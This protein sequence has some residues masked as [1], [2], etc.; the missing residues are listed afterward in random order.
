M[1]GRLLRPLITSLIRDD[2][3]ITDG[4]IYV[5]NNVTVAYLPDPSA[6]SQYWQ[7]SKPL[8]AEC[9]CPPDSACE[10]SKLASVC[11]YQ[12]PQSESQPKHKIKTTQED[13]STKYIILIAEVLLL[14]YYNINKCI[15]VSFFHHSD[16]TD[17]KKQGE[18]KMVSFLQRISFAGID[19]AKFGEV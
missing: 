6:Q 8:V 15:L 7:P 10:S 14:V 5:L 3:E 2:F 16:S 13:I 18:N 4:Q 9:H 17:D 19:I 12:I 1:L 11:W